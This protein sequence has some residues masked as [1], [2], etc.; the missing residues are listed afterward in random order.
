MAYKNPKPNL[1]D[2]PEK[3]LIVTERPSIPEYDAHNDMYFAFIDI[4]G[5]K[6][7][8][9]D[10]RD[11]KDQSFASKYEYIFRYYTH[12][13]NS[14]M[15]YDD[16]NCGAGQT[17]DSLYFYTDKIEHLIG[18][19]K[20]YLHFSLYAMSQNVFFRGG[21]A[22]GTLFVSKKHQFYG[23]CVIKAYLLESHIAKVPRIALDKNTYEDLH[24]NEEAKKIISPDNIHGRYMIKPFVSISSGELMQYFNGNIDLHEIGESTLKDIEKNIEKNS[25]RFE[26]DDKNYQKYQFLKAEFENEKLI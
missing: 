6:Q 16:K 12:L 5:F 19:L 10:N 26:F 17:S 9:D 2:K 1:D 25:S 14:A 7:T 21:I 20:I 4:L 13:M 23:D 24:S 3:Q 15:F 22:K 11:E 18:F 8:F